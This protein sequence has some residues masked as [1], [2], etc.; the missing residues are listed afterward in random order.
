MVKQGDPS[1]DIVKRVEN[2]FRFYGVVE[3]A[4]AK[5]GW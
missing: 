3:K 5:K 1:Y 4:D 2:G